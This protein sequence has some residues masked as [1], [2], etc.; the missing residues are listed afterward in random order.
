MKH[1]RKSATVGGLKKSVNAKM[2]YLGF[3]D[4]PHATHGKGSTQPTIFGVYGKVHQDAY[5]VS[6]QQLVKDT[7][8]NPEPK[9]HLISDSGMLHHHGNTERSI[10][11][12]K[13]HTHYHG[14]VYGQVPF[15]GAQAGG[16]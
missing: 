5:H 2:P 9:L 14:S 16:H 8:H 12:H 15:P 3:V 1:L 4:R 10:L 6:L 11:S 13:P 7:K